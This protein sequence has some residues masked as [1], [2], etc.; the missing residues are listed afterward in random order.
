[1]TAARAPVGLIAGAGSYP[2][3]FAARAKAMGIP[4][5]TLGVRNLASPSLAELSASFGWV[6][7]GKLGRSIRWFPNERASVKL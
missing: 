5:A 4:V 7:L 1:M 3:A 2:I 6:G